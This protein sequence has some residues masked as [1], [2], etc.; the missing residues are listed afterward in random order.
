M[1]VG[2]PERGRK[3]FK[4]Q[5]ALCHNIAAGAEH[6]TGPNLYGIVGQKSGT[7]RGY[8]YTDESQNK[9]GLSQFLCF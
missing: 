7:V 9:G 2:D 5:C 4:Q 1:P 8:E 3:L 6:K